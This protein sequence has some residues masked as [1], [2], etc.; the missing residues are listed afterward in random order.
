MR[1]LVSE[2]S[3]IGILLRRVYMQKLIWRHVVP[4]TDKNI[5]SERRVTVERASL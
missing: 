4:L 1:L 3:M 5:D 2:K